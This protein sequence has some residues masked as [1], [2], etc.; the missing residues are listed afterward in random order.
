M[1]SNGV[2]NSTNSLCGTVVEF[3]CE[4]C[5]HLSGLKLLECQPDQSWSGSQ[6]IC[7]GKLMFDWEV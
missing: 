4:S 5:Y 3:G 2:K 7:E 6:P 1:P